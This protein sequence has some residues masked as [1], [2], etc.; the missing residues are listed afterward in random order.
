MPCLLDEA[1]DARRN[2]RTVALDI[3]RSSGPGPPNRTRV[4]SRDSLSAPPCRRV[5]CALL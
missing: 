5:W 1:S 2:R 3:W 4:P